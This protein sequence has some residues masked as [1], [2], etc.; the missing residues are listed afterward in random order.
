MVQFS[1]TGKVKVGFGKHRTRG[2]VLYELER[3][4]RTGG[5]TSI[6]AGADAALLEIA[7]SRRSGARLIIIIISDG[8]SQDLW[9]LVQV[10]Q[11]LLLCEF[12]KKSDFRSVMSVR[13]PACLMPSIVETN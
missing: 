11:L 12:H 6:V 10:Q 1:D 3:I 4:E 7:T 5:R 8:N 13:L 9:E 2:D